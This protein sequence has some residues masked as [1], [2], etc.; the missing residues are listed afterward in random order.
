MS[1]KLLQ[2]FFGRFIWDEKLCAKDCVIKTTLEIFVEIKQNK[3]VK[4]SDY[5]T[6]LYI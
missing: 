2:F 1:R 3:Y 6:V 5:D 4:S